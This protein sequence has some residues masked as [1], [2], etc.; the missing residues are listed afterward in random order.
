M[1]PNFMIGRNENPW[2]VIILFG[3]VICGDLPNQLF[4]IAS[5]I[6]ET[7]G[8]ELNVLAV[9]TEKRFSKYKKCTPQL[10]RKLQRKDL[11]GFSAAHVPS[12][13]TD[14]ATL[15]SIMVSA[16]R[17][18]FLVSGHSDLLNPDPTTISPIIRDVE[19]VYPIRYGYQYV[20]DKYYGPGLHAVGMFLYHYVDK[21][22]LPE[23]SS[24]ETNRT[25]N[26][27]NRGNEKMPQGALRDVF[28]LNLLSQIHRSRLIDGIPLFDWIRQDPARG[29][30]ENISQALWAWHV[31]DDKCVELGDKFEAAGLL[32]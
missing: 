20:I 7:A 13:D 31:P 23:F 22:K 18:Q 21:R 16:S 3:G 10:L 9:H 14:A 30:L 17:S 2:T 27:F 5:N 28:P 12:G 1:D 6:I 29:H 26:W 15:A 4:R 8:L 32:A 11:I 24:S 19:T 25:A